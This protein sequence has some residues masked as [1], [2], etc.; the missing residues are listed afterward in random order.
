[1]TQQEFE[2]LSGH[3]I[4]SKSYE[5]IERIYN[6]TSLTKEEFVKE[7]GYISRGIDI[8][9]SDIV[10]ELLIKIEIVRKDLELSLA[11]IDKNRKKDIER[12]HLFIDKACAYGD[13]ALYNEA[14]DIL[15][16]AKVIKYKII[17]NLPMWEKDQKF[18]LEVLDNQ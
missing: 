10:S 11:H 5:V 16:I 17:S 9:E 12:A 15:G 4:D 8:L 7:V 13:V 14:V 3:E 6:E 1:M 18:L 2:K